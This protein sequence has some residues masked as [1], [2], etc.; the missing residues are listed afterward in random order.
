MRG[1]GRIG[2]LACF[3]VIVAAAH[4]ALA[5]PIVHARLDTDRASF[6]IHR[7][8]TYVET[9]ELD[10]TLF[11]QRGLRER[12]RSA[13][14]YYPESQSL[15][16][17]EAW[18]TQP[19]GTRLTVGPSQIFTRPSSASEGAPG[20]TGSL[21]TTVLYPQLHE[22]SHTHIIW[23]LTQKT[24]PL[25]GVNIWS[26]PPFEWPMTHGEVDVAA[27]AD[28]NLPWRSRGGFKVT[29]TVADGVRHIAATLDDTRGEEA[30][31]Y[32]V[33]T[34]D[35]QPMF[36][37]TSLS[38]LEQ[39]GAIYYR[40]SREKVVVTPAISDLA[41]RVVGND[42]GLAAA[43]D[44]YD[45]VATNI[46][47]VAVFLNPNDGYVPHPSDQVLANG[48]GDCKDHVVLMQALL[49]ARGIHADAALIDWGTRTKDMPLWTPDQFNHAIVYLP[50]F[51]MFANPTNPYARFEALD[52]RLSGKTAVV[53][54]EQGLVLKTPPSGPATN[55]YEIDS[56]L[57]ML[58]DGTLE[59]QAHMALSASLDSGMRTA[60]ANAPT[61][62][63]LADRLLTYTPEGGTGQLQTSNPRDLAHPFDI[64]ATWRSPH[65]VAFQGPDAYMTVPSGID[66]ESPARL[67]QYLSPTGKR[68]HAMLA[69]S[70]DY[71]WTTT[72][73]PPPGI[74][75][76][77]LPPD[78][79]FSNEAGR[80]T[81]SY[82]RDG[83][84][85]HVDRHLVIDRDVY[86][87]S[88]YPDLQ[89]LL[90]APIDDARAA[91]VLEREEQAVR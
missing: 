34:S 82:Q 35:F 43:R 13:L 12:E 84:V 45:W 20:F 58:P 39:I 10:Y 63:D 3:V 8:L 70:G 32:M 15:E 76:M 54:T 40:Q 4:P 81:A 72:I 52:R 2:L 55:H 88:D 67:R 36:L 90:Y 64:A 33:S 7:D 62:H 5:Q 46:R 19:D 73:A 60:V 38:S 91:I 87:A 17:V 79:D 41:A 50:D 29:D 30:E 37:L 48:F 83:E 75:V 22:G 65:G 86:E 53:A 31:R 77:T 56:K 47:Y 71:H 18:V 57:T 25:L 89:A 59:G 14:D 21:T 11:T 6:E 26:Q 16:V 66:I 44:I 28:L 42:E 9:V 69:D 23:R 85:I 24:P 74:S 1:F 68:R 80:Y 78:V 61:T 49:R 51:N 27:P